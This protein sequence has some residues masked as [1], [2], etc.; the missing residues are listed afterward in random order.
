[1]REEG[2]WCLSRDDVCDGNFL[3]TAEIYGGAGRAHV[4]LLRRPDTDREDPRAIRLQC[5]LGCKR[6]NKTREI[7]LKICNINHIELSFL[8]SL[9]LCASP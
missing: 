5:S 3:V 2:I 1:V 9:I 8:V 7:S 4:I 6:F